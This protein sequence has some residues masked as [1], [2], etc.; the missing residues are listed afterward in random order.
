MPIFKKQ[1]ELKVRDN[2][3]AIVGWEEGVAGQIHSWLEKIGV[4]HIAC[5]VNPSD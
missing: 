2:S 4:H 5:F 1:F 3:V